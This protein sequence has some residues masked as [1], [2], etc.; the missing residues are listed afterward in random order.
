M[1]A[2]GVVFVTAA[3]ACTCALIAAPTS[4]NAAASQSGPSGAHRAS[5]PLVSTRTSTG[6]GTLT[7]VAGADRIATSIAISQ[8]G[9]PSSRSALAVVLATSD[10]FADALAGGPLAAHSDG[11]VLLTPPTGLSGNVGAEIQRV[12]PAGHTVY[13]LGGAAALSSAV[14]TSVASLGFV[15]VRIAGVDRADTAV[16]IAQT[17]GDP[18]TIFEVD[19]TS[20]ADGLSAGPAAALSHGAVLLTMG[21]SPAAETVAYL[22]L[23][24]KDRLYAVGGPASTADPSALPLVGADRYATSV[25]VAN[26]LFAAPSV[27][28]LASGEVDADALSGGPVA[29]LA[30]A[31]L[32]LVPSSGPLPPTVEAY[33]TKASDTVLSALLF[34]GTAA[35]STAEANSIA[36]ALV[37]VPSAT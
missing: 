15:P 33:L 6:Q 23:H 31:P 11:P 7:R 35:I 17:L 25:V 29:A 20:F 9:F 34:G 37:L 14:D 27:V 3:L 22:G 13:I 12:L 10:T 2:S 21:A 16:K 19:G 32:I 5:T 36:Q 24:P 1:P 4:A 30:G 26:Q 28:D 8:A 18:P